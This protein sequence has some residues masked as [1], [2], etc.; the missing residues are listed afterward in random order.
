MGFFSRLFK[1]TKKELPIV[2]LSGAKTYK[3]KV[4]GTSKYQNTLEKL[5]GGRGKESR[6]VIFDNVLLIHLDDDPHDKL[7][8][9]VSIHGEPVGYLSKENARQFRKSLEEGGFP[10]SG[11]VC[12]GMIIGGWD[13]G[14][15]DRGH[16]GMRLDLPTG[17]ENIEDFEEISDSLDFSFTLDQPNLEELSRIKVGGGVNFWQPGIDPTKIF[18]YRSGSVGGEGKIGRVPIKYTKP[19]SSQI[20]LKLPIET[21]IF[22]ITSSG[23]VIHCKLVTAEEV[24]R[25]KCERQDKLRDE[26]SKPYRPK[27]PVVFFADAQSYTFDPGEQLHLTRIPSIDEYVDTINEMVLLFSSLDGKKTLEKRNEPSVKKKVIRMARTFNQLDIRVVSK[28]EAPSWLK[29]EYKIQIIP[30]E[31]EPEPPNPA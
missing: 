5:C 3:I 29:S 10:G 31:T 26:I 21:E 4:V 1:K 25:M 14:E 7:A 17:D 23:C 24:N 2:N 16:F 13:D 8:I 30:A 9:L 6:E 12:S 22:E 20:K 28:V 27:S 15:G 19:I 11:A 18:V